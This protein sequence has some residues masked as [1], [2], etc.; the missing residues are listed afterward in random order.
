M[1]VPAEPGSWKHFEH[2]H[3]YNIT[4]SYVS[5][6]ATTPKLPLASAPLQRL[7]VVTIGHKLNVETRSIQERDPHQNITE[8]VVNVVD[9]VGGVVTYGPDAAIYITASLLSGS[10]TLYGTTTI[11]AV[12]GVARFRGLKIGYGGAPGVKQLRF[13]PNTAGEC[14]CIAP[15]NSP[16]I[17]IANAKVLSPH[18]PKLWQTF[19][20]TFPW[21]RSR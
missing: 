15:G 2:G 17:T 11:Q 7:R 5:A 10:G 21:G 6:N 12:G 3:F 8:I 9:E 18:V 14:G 19:P 4:A 20:W 13:T 16:S 1:E